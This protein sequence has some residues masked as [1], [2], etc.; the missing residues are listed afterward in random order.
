M[1]YLIEEKL[2]P[3]LNSIYGNENVVRQYRLENKKIVDYMCSSDNKN[4][5]VEFDGW[6]HYTQ[7]KVIQRDSD[8]D[9]LLA[10]KGIEIIHV[11]YW[12]QIET[13]LPVLFGID[14]FDKSTVCGIFNDYKNGFND[15]KC[16]HPHDYNIN[17]WKR[18]INEL[19][20]LP[21]DIRN[22]VISTFNVDDMECYTIMSKI[23]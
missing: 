22:G 1:D 13:V 20:R 2:Y 5:V 11:P 3:I 6:Q 21:I 19:N 4:V 12:L 10:S 17:G 15:S 23:Q 9:T 8:V 16:I 14:N 7:Q 18:F